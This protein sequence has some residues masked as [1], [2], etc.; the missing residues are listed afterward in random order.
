MSVQ[1]GSLAV[2]WLVRR[3][4]RETRETVGTEARPNTFHIS[5][6][7]GRYANNRSQACPTAHSVNASASSTQPSSPSR[8]S[9][10]TVSAIAGL[11]LPTRA[12]FGIPPFLDPPFRAVDPSHRLERT[13]RRPDDRS[14]VIFT[15][16]VESMKALCKLDSGE[17]SVSTTTRG[18]FGVTMPATIS[19]RFKVGGASRRGRALDGGIREISAGFDPSAVV[20]WVRSS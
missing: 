1:S 10:M 11:F 15:E 12:F 16:M 7:R 2:C 5:R 18:S 13:S 6:A 4:A 3:S 14:S 19:A 8:P 9:A 20:S 17:L